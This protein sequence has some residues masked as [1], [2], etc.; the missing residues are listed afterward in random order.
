ADEDRGP[1]PGPH[2]EE[3]RE[4][5]RLEG[6]RRGPCFETRTEL[7]IGPRFARTRWCAPQHEVRE[8]NRRHML[9]FLGGAVGWPLAARAQQPATPVVGFLRSVPPI[10]LQ[11]L[12]TPFRQGLREA[13]FVE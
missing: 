1:K 6:W 12:L 10:G 9:S 5:M 8:M 3:H 2:P 13:G 7:V 11:D 4:A